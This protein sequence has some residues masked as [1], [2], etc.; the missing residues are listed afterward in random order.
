MMSGRKLS[1]QLDVVMSNCVELPRLDAYQVCIL[2]ADVVLLVH[3]FMWYYSRCLCDI[4]GML[5]ISKTIIFLQLPQVITNKTVMLFSGGV[6]EKTGSLSVSALSAVPLWEKVWHLFC[7][8]EDL[9][10]VQVLDVSILC[11]C[12]A[13]WH[14]S[15]FI[16]QNPEIAVR[17]L[18]LI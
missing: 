18:Q 13:L 3:H 5:S 9:C 11:A 8:W 4:T 7:G 17:E 14:F 16:L 6:C 15:S 12:V 10:P 1:Q 2:C